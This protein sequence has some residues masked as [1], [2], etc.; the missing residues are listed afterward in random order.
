[1]FVL[2]P[3]YLM[4]IYLSLN[5]ESFIFL[6]LLMELNSLIFMFM[7]MMELN[8][9]MN[10]NSLILMFIYQMMTASF[11]FIFLFLIMNYN[12]NMMTYMIY[13]LLFIK[14]G[15]SPFHKWYKF[16]LMNLPWNMCFMIST[17]Y[18][19]MPFIFFYKLMLE[20]NEFLIN[21]SL[22]S[23]FLSSFKALMT[24][25]IKMIFT[26]SS[27]IHINFMIIMM[28][29]NINY[30]LIYFMFYTCLIFFFCYFMLKFQINY[31]FDL[32]TL[33]N[34]IY[35]IMIFLNIMSM[36]GMPPSLMFMIK[37]LIYSYLINNY[38]LLLSML[39]MMMNIFMMI[40]YLLMSLPL[41]I[42]INLNCNFYLKTN[43]LLNKKEKLCFYLN[44]IFIFMSP[45]MLMLI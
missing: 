39:M 35:K 21:M 23:I 16:T 15:L 28:M 8:K 42:N 7:I 41:M 9:L 24:K 27:I 5:M 17:I 1:M 32:F 33:G 26:Y 6:W 20:N 18:K 19:I 37:Y 3:I 29:I 12:N 2:F 43:K 14:L 4:L 11:L 30:M 25:N 22:I 10:L 34:N 38:S 36:M 40:F 13:I 31:N 45:M 44:L